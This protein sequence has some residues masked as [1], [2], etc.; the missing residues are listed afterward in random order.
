VT[1]LAAC[2]AAAGVLLVARPPALRGWVVHRPRAA[3][4]R[5]SRRVPRLRGAEQP[6]HVAL[7]ADL[8]VAAL[9]AGAA[10]PVAMEAVA[11]AVGGP[12]GAMLGDA[13]RRH[14]VGGDLVAATEVLCSAP[15]TRRV[16]R[17]LG[18]AGSSGASPVQVLQ[19]AADSERANQRSARVSQ[20]RAAGSLAALPVGLLFLP[21]FVLVAVVPVVV[22]SLGSLLGGS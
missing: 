18:R 14:R 13:S 6:G 10:L 7:A 12:T 4:R 1:A 3:A 8:L 15:Q 21:A 20:A 11:C 16:G 22:G 2:L 17:A 19:A 5:S 9:A